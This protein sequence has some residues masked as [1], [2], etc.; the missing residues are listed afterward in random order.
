MIN[1]P[2]ADECL[3]KGQAKVLAE[4][5]LLERIGK[6]GGMIKVYYDGKGGWKVTTIK[7]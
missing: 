1:C 4:M 3:T 2:L 6:G 7:K 5:R